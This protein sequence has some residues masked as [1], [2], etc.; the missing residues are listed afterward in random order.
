[1]NFK[2]WRQYGALNSGPVFDAFSRGVDVCGHN[3]TS[4][5]NDSSIDVIWSVLFSG[6]MANNAQVWD[7]AQE[8]KKSVVVLEVGSILRNKTW[9][10][11][12]NGITKDCFN[13]MPI[14]DSTRPAKLGLHLREWNYNGKYILIC[15]QNEKSLLW[16]KMPRMKHW[17]EQ[18]ISE[19]RK[20]TDRTIVF[21]PHPRST[22]DI[23]VDAY[24]NVFV[25]R[26]VKLRGSKDDYPIDFTNVWATVSYNSGPGVASIL[27]GSPAFVDNTSLASPMSSGAISNIESPLRPDREQWLTWLSHTEFTV[28]EISQ[29]FPINHLTNSL[30]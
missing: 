15:G 18:T 7:A 23:N 13:Y 30:K 16:D 10:I 26:P 25:D 14:L 19:I 11:G 22:V 12:I 9:K 8:K 29:G 2:L 3:C 28:E 24:N 27:H 20:Y 5:N 17:V 1:M 6:R 21:R 4:N